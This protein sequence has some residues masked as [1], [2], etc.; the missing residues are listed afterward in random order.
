MNSVPSLRE[1]ERVAGGK[2]RDRGRENENILGFC[3]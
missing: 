3:V 2:D 1:K